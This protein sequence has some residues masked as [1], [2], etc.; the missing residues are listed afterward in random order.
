MTTGIAV[1]ALA[2]VVGAAGYAFNTNLTVGSTG[3]DVVALQQ[4][5]MGMGYDIPAIS[6]GAATTGYFGSQTV[7]AVKAYQ[8]ANG[9][10]ATGFVGPLTRG[11]LNAGVTG[12]AAASTCPAGQ[13]KLVYQGVNY[14]CLPTPLVLMLGQTT[15]G[16]VTTPTTPGTITTPGVVG[17]LTASLW[18]T[19]SNGTT[20]YKGQAYDIATLKLQAGASDMAVQNLSVD[21]N[22][23]MWLYAGAITVKDD[24]GAVI[25]SVSNLSQSSFT[26]LTVGSD[27][28][29][30]VPVSGLV[31]KATQ[32]KYLTVNMS[33]LTNS[34]KCSSTCVAG[35]TSFQ[36]RAIDGTGVTD[37]QTVNATTVGSS[38]TATNGVAVIR[39]FSY[40]GT[41]SGNLVVSVDPTSPKQ[42]QVSISTSGQTQDVLLAVYSVKPTNQN[43]TLRTLKIGVGNGGSV[44]VAT[45]F[46]NLKLR[47]DSLTGVTYAASTLAST[48]E[49]TNLN[50]PL[51]A[52]V[53]TKLSI[54]GTVNQD[55]NNALDGST[56]S[57]SVTLSTTNV[58]VEDSTYNTVSMASD[59]QKLVSS[60]L[61]FSASAASI[62]DQQFAIA[63]PGSTSSGRNV[64][65]LFSGSFTV[66]TGNSG[67]YISVTPGKAFATTTAY[68]AAA[69]STIQTFTSA[70]G[71]QGGDITGSFYYVGPNST[72][73]FNIGGTL[74][75]KNGTAGAKSFG[76]TAIYFTDDTTAGQERKFNVNYNLQG[77]NSDQHISVLLGA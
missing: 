24:T 72:R 42:G 74:D 67:V 68:G 25:G 40:Q 75:N 47:A 66:S 9:I 70:D 33:F 27:Y 30:S 69:S 76:V 32:T 16:A 39:S 12:G 54:Y 50:I 59:G 26:E 65:T 31:V 13:S 23:R 55:T 56:A 29:I 38:V 36:V 6:S 34:D 11:A 48:T 15:P 20:V 21:F 61:S 51:P 22:D 19:P 45:L 71:T 4:A 37:T 63:D 18:S 28:R 2:T 8:A 73:K 60:V 43:S 41:N 62:G 52:D 7:T 35:V 57:T 46:A 77:L 5:L 64:N 14:G 44:S 53:Y 58:S 10:P 49:F 3:A 1:L 17:T